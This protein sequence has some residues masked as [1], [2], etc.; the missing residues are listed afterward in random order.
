MGAA[1]GAQIATCVP[2]S[3]GCKRD[4]TAH[5]RLEARRAQPHTEQSETVIARAHTLPS[6]E[7]N[8]HGT[9]L[10]HL[11]VLRPCCLADCLPCTSVM[12]HLRL[13][14]A[15]AEVGNGR[16]SN[17]SPA[18][19]LGVA[20]GSK[21]FQSAMHHNVAWQ[22]EGGGEGRG[23]E[24]LGQAGTHVCAFE[25][26]PLTSTEADSACSARRAC[27]CLVHA[28]TS[29]KIPSA[30][31]CRRVPESRGG[32]VSACVLDSGLQLWGVDRPY[33][34]LRKAV[35]DAAQGTGCMLGELKVVRAD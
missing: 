21:R 28:F 18:W 34:I 23:G 25:C 27:L 14:W 2:C 19:L 33:H 9:L 8:T 7:R 30:S 12:Q 3:V 11:I 10:S 1:A 15:N 35:R 26:A 4:Q 6:F 32:G 31:R 24:R 5:D 17:L 20:H 16:R 13:G 29:G 22:R